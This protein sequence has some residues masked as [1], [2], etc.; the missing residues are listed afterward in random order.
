[1][2]EYEAPLYGHITVDLTSCNGNAMALVAKA[3]VAARRGGLSFREIDEFSS[4]ALSGG[5]DRVMQTVM[6]WF[7]VD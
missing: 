7:D 6:K 4:E 1:M 2:Y 5:Y 3:R